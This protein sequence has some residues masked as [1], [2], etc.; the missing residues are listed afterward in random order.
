MPGSFYHGGMRPLTLLLL[1]LVLPI[2]HAGT[3]ERAVTSLSL[4]ELLSAMNDK[5]VSRYLGD[6]AAS[7]EE[8]EQRAAALLVSM[9]LISA[10]DIADGSA[11]RK[12][13]VAVQT[14]LA[15]HGAFRGRLGE[16]T[17]ITRLASAFEHEAL[18]TDNVFLDALSGALSEGVITGYD[19]RIK[20]IYDGFPAGMT[21]TYS[22]SDLVHMQQL[23]T[24]LASEGVDGWLY[25]TPKVSAFLFREDWGP[26]GDAVVTLPGGVRVLQGREIAALFHFDTKQDRDRFHEVVLRYAK[27]DRPD[28]AG[29][30]RNAWWQPFYYADEDI[31]GFEPISLIVLSSGE[32]EATLTVLPEKTEQVLASL[33][34]GV[35]SR[36]I[37]RV[38]V[39]P[40]FHRF[41]H[42]DYK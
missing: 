29:L 12:L 38:W 17:L 20:G 26:A 23:V 13:N 32:H 4:S 39:N 36:R 33:P 25:V 19:L 41:L 21:F 5:K 10:G 6:T 16:P 31:P 40:A 42:G 14:L 7:L 22:Q 8:K 9:Q 11:A 34:D 2:T 30:I 35:W 28:E 1:L 37:D 15:D 3:Y 18:L 24:L 27:K